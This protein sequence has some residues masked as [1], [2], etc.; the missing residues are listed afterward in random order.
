MQQYSLQPTDQLQKGSCSSTVQYK[1]T[2]EST[3]YIK[4][5]TFGTVFQQAYDPTRSE[6]CVLL[7][8]FMVYQFNPSTDL[9]LHDHHCSS[10][11][12][13]QSTRPHFHRAALTQLYSFARKPPLLQRV[14]H[15][16]KGVTCYQTLDPDST[17]E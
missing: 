2:A 16:N 6:R 9:V 15:I 13:A 14:P 4:F 17:A 3:T 11:R 10:D 1:L 5:V 12:C 8:C 7:L